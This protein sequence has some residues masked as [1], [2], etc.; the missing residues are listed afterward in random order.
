MARL[1]ERVA[2]RIAAEPGEIAFV[3][4]AADTA[5]RG[6]SEGYET[7]RG[8]GPYL[9]TIPDF[10][11]YEGEGVRT[12]KKGDCI[13]QVPGSV[14]RRAITPYT[15]NGTRTSHSAAITPPTAGPSTWPRF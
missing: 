4:V 13:N 8:Y 2:R 10:G 15:T 12:I 9:G 3:K 1:V 6:A 5:G 7:T 14:E 11:E